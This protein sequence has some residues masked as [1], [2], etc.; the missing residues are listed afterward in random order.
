MSYNAGVRLVT[1]G[2][3]HLEGS[4]FTR[5]KPLLLLCYLA[6]EGGQPR[7]S[8]TPLFFSNA[9]HPR[10]ALSTSLRRLRRLEEGVIEVDRETIKTQV[11]CDALELLDHLT[12][13][14]MEAALELYNGPFLQGFTQPLGEELEEWVFRQRESLAGH[15]RQVLL[16]LGEQEATLKAFGSAAERAAQAYLL[17]GAPEPEAEDFWRIYR[18]LKAGG[19]ALTVEVR[20]EAEAVGL[21]L[22]LRRAEAR[23]LLAEIETEPVTPPPENPYQGLAAF[24]EEDAELFFGRD[25]SIEKLLRAV[26]EQML[27]GVVG[28][29]GSGKSSLL[30]AGLIPTLRDEGAWII[31]QIRPGRSPFRALSSALIT[32]LEPGLRHADHLVESKKLASRLRLGDLDLIKVIERV[33]E[34]HLALRLLLIVDQFEEL[35]NIGQ[36]EPTD[37]SRGGELGDGAVLETFLEQLFSAVRLTTD[38]FRLV[39]TVRADFMAQVLS[40][41]PLV[42]QLQNNQFLLGPMSEGELREAIERPAKL[43]GV[44]FEEGLVTRILKDVAGREGNLPLLEFTLEQLWERQA[45]RLTHQGYDAIGGVEQALASHADRTMESLTRSERTAAQQVFLQLVHPGEGQE[46]TRRVAIRAELGEQSWPLVSRLAT[47]RLVVTGRDE[48][49]EQTV[50]LIHEALIRHWGMLRA[51]V[52]EHRAFRIWQDQLRQQVRAWLSSEQD[53]GTLLGGYYLEEARQK[54]DTYEDHLGGNERDFIHTSINHYERELAERKAQQQRVLELEMRRGRQFRWLSFVLS[55]LFLA[56]VTAAG[57]AVN[58]QRFAQRQSTLVAT[59]A[60]LARAKELSVHGQFV[61]E[62]EPLLGVR[63]A[64]EGLALFPDGEE[65]D[66]ITHMEILRDLTSLGRLAKIGSDIEEIISSENSPFIIVDR[67]DEPGN[68]IDVS[69]DRQIAALSGQV[70]DVWFGLDTSVFLVDYED[71]PDEVRI[72][73]DPGSAFVLTGEINTVDLSSDGSLFLV[74]YLDAA[75]EVRFSWNPESPIVIANTVNFYRAQS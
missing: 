41:R 54:L 5:F 49:G 56:A 9:E 2:G 4:N 10:N 20:K 57:V 66:L 51:W 62:E 6:L 19:H 17:P 3:L 44:K 14:R 13:G 64:V 36:G 75:N 12:A 71:A 25:A 74:D 70:A 60:Q 61:F 39:L 22:T 42:D 33:W 1:L 52:N 59:T 24:R 73:A 8:L 67:G 65:N 68:L 72:I 21:T 7:G 58:R 43:R 26:K 47:A 31:T 15:V 45:G 23:R 27:T 69:T 29:S 53:E 16:Y 50:E 30:A 63:L 18:L 11:T 38:R 46:D 40:Y 35:Y 55:G 32:L 34:K 48:S 28:G 37:I